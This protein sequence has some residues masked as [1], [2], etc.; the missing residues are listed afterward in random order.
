MEEG[1]YPFI[2]TGLFRPQW[3]WFEFRGGLIVSGKD[4]NLC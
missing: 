3:T 4:A 1:Q 2:G